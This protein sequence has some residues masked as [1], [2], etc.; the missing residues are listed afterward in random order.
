MKSINLSDL[1]ALA[2]GATATTPDI[3]ELK[4][5]KSVE[6]SN[7]AL[8]EAIA[9]RKE[10][11]ASEA[12]ERAADALVALLSDAQT[13][14]EH[15]LQQLRMVR[16]QEKSLLAQIKQINVAQAYANATNNFLPLLVAIGSAP[17][18]VALDPETSSLMDVPQAF[19]DEYFAEKKTAR[20]ARAK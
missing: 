5:Y 12:I 6:I 1:I 17:A 2:K 18:S 13:S 16:N 19:V 4:G 20:T 15:R 8:K 7:P 11:E 9:R 3:P 10:K 14:M